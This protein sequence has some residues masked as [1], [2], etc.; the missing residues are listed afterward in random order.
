MSICYRTKSR[1]KLGYIKQSFKERICNLIRSFFKCRIVR[2]NSRSTH[3]IKI[4]IVQFFNCFVKKIINKV[5]IPN[6]ISLSPFVIVENQYQISKALTVSRNNDWK[7]FR[8]SPF[9]F[10]TFFSLFIITLNKICIDFIE[11]FSIK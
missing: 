4:I 9:T 5:Q 11:I 2:A 8:M 6:K 10:Y 1:R 3:F 7:L